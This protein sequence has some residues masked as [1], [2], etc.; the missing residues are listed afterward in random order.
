MLFAGTCLNTS[1][2]GLKKENLIYISTGRLM[3]IH[4][5]VVVAGRWCLARVVCVA[6]GLGGGET[7]K[8]N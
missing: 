6:G 1:D 2:L 8:Q 3:Q 7:E 4:L 5:E